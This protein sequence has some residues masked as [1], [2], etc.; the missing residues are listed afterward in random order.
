VPA[1]EGKVREGGEMTKKTRPDGQGPKSQD[2]RW[3]AF[4]RNNWDRRPDHYGTGTAERKRLWGG[5]ISPTRGIFEGT[6]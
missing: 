6:V 3:I 2:S 4:S 1:R 5:K